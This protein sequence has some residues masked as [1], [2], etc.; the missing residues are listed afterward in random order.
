MNSE[1]ILLDLIFDSNLI[2]VV[3]LSFKTTRII[4]YLYNQL[5]SKRLQFEQYAY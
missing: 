3:N 1:M 5:N 4:L 2:F